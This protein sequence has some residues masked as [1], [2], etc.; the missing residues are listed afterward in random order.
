M[1][2]DLVLQNLKEN[3]G[4]LSQGRIDRLGFLSVAA[5]M[6]SNKELLFGRS[7]EDGTYYFGL[8]ELKRNKLIEVRWLK[9]PIMTKADYEKVK[10]D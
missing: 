5:T 2:E 3:N 10:Y 6:V 4:Y 8:P 7:T 1:D 9:N